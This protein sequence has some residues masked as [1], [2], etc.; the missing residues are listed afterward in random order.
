MTFKVCSRSVKAKAAVI[1]RKYA[2]DCVSAFY[3]F[4]EAAADN[5]Y[6]QAMAD[7]WR[8]FIVTSR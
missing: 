4:G 1:R 7:P 5:L 2:V 3:Y 8:I 6:G